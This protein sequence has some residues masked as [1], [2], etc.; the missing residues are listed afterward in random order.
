[1]VDSTR[2]IGS[3]SNV[4]TGNRS[5]NSREADRSEETGRSEPVDEVEISQEAIDVVKAQRLAE[6]TRA[7]LVRTPDSTLSDSDFDGLI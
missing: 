7:E 3:I 2:G 5:Q 1:M 6:E 4:Q